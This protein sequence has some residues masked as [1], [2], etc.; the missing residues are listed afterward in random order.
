ML[1]VREEDSPQPFL[2]TGAVGLLMAVLIGGLL[3]R[4]RGETPSRATRPTSPFC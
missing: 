2:V 3:L 1:R 4:R